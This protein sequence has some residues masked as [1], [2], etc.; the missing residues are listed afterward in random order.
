MGS[1]ER[2]ISRNTAAEF[3]IIHQKLQEKLHTHVLFHTILRIRNIE[4]DEI[5]IVYDKENDNNEELEYEEH[6]L[7]H[8]WHI[9][10]NNLII[11]HFQ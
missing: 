6:N 11:Q 4:N 3:C 5:N 7:L 1:G 8:E 2:Y 9:T 10:R